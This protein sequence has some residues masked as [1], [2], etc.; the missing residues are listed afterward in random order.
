MYEQENSFKR[1]NNQ[2]TVFFFQ[3]NKQQGIK[4]ENEYY[5]LTT[6]FRG[7]TRRGGILCQCGVPLQHKCSNPHEHCH[8]DHQENLEEGEYLQN[9]QK[10]SS[11]SSQQQPLQCC[12]MCSTFDTI[13]TF[14]PASGVSRVQKLAGPW[15]DTTMYIAISITHRII[16][17][18]AHARMHTQST[19]RPLMQAQ[20][21][22]ISILQQ[23][24]LKTWSLHQQS[25]E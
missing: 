4:T 17:Q 15:R 12:H 18:W 24:P 20:H 25:S 11:T 2:S 23:E 1:A 10:E 16:L 14:S 8:P 6:L 21:T 7:G 9:I 22:H 13:S 3:K 19:P 5:L